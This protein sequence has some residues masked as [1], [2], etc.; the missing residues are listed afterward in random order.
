MLTRRRR[1]LGQI[2][3][4]ILNLCQEQLVVLSWPDWFSVSDCLEVFQLSCRALNRREKFF[5]LLDDDP[6]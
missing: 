4:L 6:I 5:V 3:G 2:D 1:Q